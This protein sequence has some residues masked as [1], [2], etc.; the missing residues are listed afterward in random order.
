M[1]G[2][3]RKLVQA[4]KRPPWEWDEQAPCILLGAASRSR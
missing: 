3:R 2:L 4:A 1:D